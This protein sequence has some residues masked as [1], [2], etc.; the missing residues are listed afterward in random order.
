V[1]ALKAGKNVRAGGIFAPC[2]NPH[3]ADSRANTE[4]LLKILEETE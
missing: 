1:K 2:H 4:E 3:T